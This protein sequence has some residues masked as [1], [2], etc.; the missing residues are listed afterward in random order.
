[1]GLGQIGLGGIRFPIWEGVEAFGVLARI[2]EHLG[3][4][5]GG[6]DGRVNRP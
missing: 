4:F 2:S 1:M 6:L 5:L 3:Y